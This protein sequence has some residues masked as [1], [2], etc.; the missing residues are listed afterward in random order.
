MDINK[1]N[2]I[3]Q[4]IAITILV[5]TLI[6]SIVLSA[7][8]AKYVTDKNNSAA[9]RPAS[10]ELVME[11]LTS[12]DKIDV[13]FAADGEPG[14]PIGHTIGEKY[15]DFS[16]EMNDT[17]V[18]SDYYLIVNFNKKVADKIRQARTDRF[19]DG[20]CCDFVVLK[21]TARVADDKPVLS[22]NG[23]PVIDYDEE[24]PITENVKL[25]GLD[26][27]TGIKWQYH[28][29]IAPQK[30]PDGTV[31]GKA[32]YRLKMIFYNNTMMPST[33]NTEDYFFVTNGIEIEVKAQQINPEFIG[34]DYTETT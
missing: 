4:R 32:Y 18:A 7:V 11:E 28:S 15:Y 1:R 10:F 19:K 24:N 25:E 20:I 13:S 17:E 9:V 8:Y 16:V 5:V 2:K 3:I 21:G 33:G 30:N 22:A 27:N 12:G 23:K 26:S 34:D 14:S 29:A 31:G 6:T